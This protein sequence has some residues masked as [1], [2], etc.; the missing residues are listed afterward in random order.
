MWMMHMT[1]F[2][3]KDTDILFHKW[4]G[5]RTGMYALALVFV[6]AM[7]VLVEFLS[8]TRFIKPASN[9]LLSAL[10]K[11]FLHVL[12]VGLAYLVMLSLMSFNGGVFLA[13]I[14]GHALGFFLAAAFHKPPQ[15][16]GFDLPPVS[17]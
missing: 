1:F 8:H 3:G 17:C 4:P 15:D 16:L 10:L 9:H 14:L 12:R 2:W 7:A 11:T 5:G 13:A 6:F